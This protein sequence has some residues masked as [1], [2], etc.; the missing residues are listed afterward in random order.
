MGHK[1][2][3]QR[4]KESANNCKGVKK[5]GMHHEVIEGPTIRLRGGNGL[6]TGKGVWGN[7]G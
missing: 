6:T 1:E 3:V 2:S 4:K 7:H 5:R